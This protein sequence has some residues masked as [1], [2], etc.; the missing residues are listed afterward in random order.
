MMMVRLALSLSP[1]LPLSLFHQAARDE[2]AASWWRW[3][4]R[5]RG[6]G[7][8]EKSAVMRMVH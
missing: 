5:E 2:H 4:E 3:R 1:S 8:R 7:V 6:G